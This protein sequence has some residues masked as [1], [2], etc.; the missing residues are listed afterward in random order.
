MKEFS[1]SIKEKFKSIDKVVLFCV[2]GMNIL[3]LV[4]LAGAANEIGSR[5]LLV[6]TIASVL[7]LFLMFT[8]AFLD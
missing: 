7:G 2:I 5:Y 6:Q 1:V 8:L 4:I 3:S